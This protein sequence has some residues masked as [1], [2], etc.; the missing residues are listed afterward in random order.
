VD[1][2]QPLFQDSN[3][4]VEAAEPEVAD[5]VVAEAA[6]VEVAAEVVLEVVEQLLSE[7]LIERQPWVLRQRE[8]DAE[9]AQFSEPLRWTWH[10][11]QQDSPQR[12]SWG[13]S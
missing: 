10:Q 4:V 9:E 3:L 8:Q 1:C 5:E 7:G 6:A 11:S 12:G 13:D 2:T